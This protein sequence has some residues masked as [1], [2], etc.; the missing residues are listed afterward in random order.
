MTSLKKTLHKFNE[1]DSEL[2]VLYEDEGFRSLF[3]E[4]Q[5]FHDLLKYSFSSV[6]LS[7]DIRL[8]IADKEADLR[9]KVDE[10]IMYHMKE[11]D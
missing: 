9:M 6:S 11:E 2:E 5:F 8:Q 1:K 10:R 3:K 7:Q 4:M